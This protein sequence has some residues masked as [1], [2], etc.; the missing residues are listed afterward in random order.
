[1]NI[2]FLTDGI[3]PFQ[4]GGMQKHSF[5]LSK[6]LAQKGLQIH[7]FHCGGEGYTQ[8]AFEALYGSAISNIKESVIAFPSLGRIPGHYIREN[9]RYSQL[10]FEAIKDKIDTFDLVYAQGF[11][12][13]EFLRQKKKGVID[14]PVLVNFHGFEMFQTAANFK[15]KLSHNLLRNSVKYQI[16]NA[17]FIYSFGGK[18][19]EIL[20]QLGISKQKILL[21]SNG[22]EKS[23]IIDQAPAVKN[24]VRSFIFIGRNERRKGVEELN[25]ALLL[26]LDQKD[27]PFQFVFIGPI[28]ESIQIEDKRI[29][30]KGE[31]RDAEAIRT[32]LKNS[33][34]LLCPSHAEGMPTVILEA[35]ACHNAVIATDVGATSRMINNNGFLLNSPQPIEIMGA[36]KKIIEMD[37]SDLLKMK[38]SSVNLVCEKFTWDS[39]A[40]Q[41]IADFKKVLKE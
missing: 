40:D 13:W 25:K 27:M 41:K 33:D 36:M 1:M 37:E 26:L 3:S 10:I 8:E 11:T 28:P 18:I 29:I 16:K 21:Q 23:W 5:V 2:L 19:S 20:T 32:F 9:K 38:D 35:M 4:I 14:L 24:P 22:I 12:G 7:L 39:I 15:I 34:C 17:D 30:Y 31:I 6:L